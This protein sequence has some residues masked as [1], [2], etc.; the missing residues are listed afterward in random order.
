VAGQDV[1]SAR[2]A[3]LPGEID[4]ASC[5]AAGAELLAAVSVPGLVI[6]DLTGTT[7]CDSAGMRMLLAAYD[8]ARS[9]GASLRIAVTPGT[10]VARVMAILG[11]NRVLSVYS[12][13]DDARAHTDVRRLFPR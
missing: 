6:A 2:I 13:V 1:G 3:Q 11:L 10:S 5:G 4:V 9:S 8:R 12:S 7:C